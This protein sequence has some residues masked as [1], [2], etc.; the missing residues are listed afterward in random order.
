MCLRAVIAILLL[1]LA[2]TPSTGCKDGARRVVSE[3][4]GELQAR[5]GAAEQTGREVAERVG[6]RLAT[7]TR[8][9]VRELAAKGIVLETAGAAE[10]APASPVPRRAPHGWQNALRAPAHEAGSSDAGSWEGALGGQ[11]EIPDAPTLQRLQ[12]Q[13]QLRAEL[14]RQRH[15]QQ[16]QQ[17]QQAPFPR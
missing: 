17:L 7:L 15:Q 13:E 14:A 4:A 8:L 10:E 11:A 9:A 5:R 12:Q 6:R 3:V 1:A 2:A 16:W